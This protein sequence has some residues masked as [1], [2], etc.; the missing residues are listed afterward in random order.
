MGKHLKR[1]LCTTR[2]TVEQLYYATQDTRGGLIIT[3]DISDVCY[4]L[5]YLV[6]KQELLESVITKGRESL[7]IFRD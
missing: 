1:L 7:S 5:D 2:R 4:G 3:K 6:A